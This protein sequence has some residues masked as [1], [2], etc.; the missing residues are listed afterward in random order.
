MCCIWLAGNAGPKNLPSGHHRT[1]L[2]RY[3]FANKARIDNRK[4][5]VKQQYLP[6]MSLQYGE[7]SPL[8]A[9]IGSLVWST[10]ANFNGFHVFASLLQRRC[11]TEANQILQNVCPSPVLI[12]Y[13][14]IFGGSCHIT[15]FARC[16][17]HFASK[18]CT[19]LYF[20]HF[21]TALE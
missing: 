9:E 3:I 6:H 20:Q 18:S 14:Y 7:L 4:K 17:V 13:I 5:L 21:C 1:T 12:Y 2:S 19:L 8:A 15:E 11:S 10:P 16:T